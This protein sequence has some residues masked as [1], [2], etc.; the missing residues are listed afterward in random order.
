MANS[1]FEIRLEQSRNGYI[2]KFLGKWVIKNFGRT[3]GGLK[4]V[5]SL[6]IFL[7]GGTKLSPGL[8]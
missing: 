8:S 2:L 6:E 7:F 5:H 3:N 4:R 1:L